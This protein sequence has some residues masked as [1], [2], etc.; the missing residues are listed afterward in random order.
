MLFIKKVLH[1]L[2]FHFD[3]ICWV[4]VLHQSGTEWE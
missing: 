2:L 3:L 4:A 1:T